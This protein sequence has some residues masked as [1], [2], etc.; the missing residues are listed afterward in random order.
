MIFSVERIARI[1]HEANSSLCNAE[2]DYS[3]TSWDEA[4]DWQKSLAVLGVDYL[5]SNPSIT[6]SDLHESWSR[7]RIED[8]WKYGQH[9]DPVAK[10]HPCLV[11]FEQLPPTQQAKDYLFKA[12]VLTLAQIQ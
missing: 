9:K 2:G 6:V 4:P 5:I 8:G 1:T 10:I 3:Q 11:P 12:I 7:Q